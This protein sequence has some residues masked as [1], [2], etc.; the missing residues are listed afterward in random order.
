M[1]KKLSIIIVSIIFILGILFVF[2]KSINTPEKVIKNHIKYI[3]EHNIDKLSNT[4]TY[5]LSDYMIENIDTMEL[6]SLEL[7]NDESAYDTY[8]RSGGGQI[9]DNLS[10]NNVKI[11]KVKYYIKYKDDTKSVTGSGEF[12]R[13]YYLIKDKDTGL[14]KINDLG[15]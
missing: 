14:W 15:E 4:V 12:I 6:I 11:Y 8:I 1:N 3:N 5:E 13:N 2:M 7:V 10:I 9:I